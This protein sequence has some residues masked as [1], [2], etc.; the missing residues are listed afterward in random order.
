M[1]RQEFIDATQKTFGQYPEKLFRLMDTENS[2]IASRQWMVYLI[3]AVVYGTDTGRC[4]QQTK[5]L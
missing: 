4:K 3:L 2:L 5:Y 1:T